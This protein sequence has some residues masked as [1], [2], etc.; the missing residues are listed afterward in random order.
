MRLTLLVQSNIGN[1][2]NCA[3]FNSYIWR[4]YRSLKPFIVKSQVP[5]LEA[6][7]C[8]HLISTFC[9]FFVVWILPRLRFSYN[10]W[11][12][13]LWDDFSYYFSLTRVQRF[14][15]SLRLVTWSVTLV[16]DT[17]LLLTT[18][19]IIT[20]TDEGYSYSTLMCRFRHVIGH[21]TFCS[22]TAWITTKSVY[23]TTFR[24]SD[25]NARPTMKDISF[26][27]F[28][29][30]Q[31]YPAPPAEKFSLNCLVGVS[32]VKAVCHYSLVSFIKWIRL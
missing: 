3:T 15:V 25:P 8:D 31:K 9:D 27:L 2:V 13:T 6:F 5:F 12:P 21:R 22:M 11:C 10:Q 24:V 18:P 32:R 17:P 20:V 1:S 26:S 16:W 4:S 14:C 23:F 29:A 28:K 7:N 30:S 19:Q